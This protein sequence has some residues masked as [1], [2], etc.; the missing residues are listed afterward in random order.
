MSM[1]SVTCSICIGRTQ[2]HGCSLLTA[3]STS[4]PPMCPIPAI[5]QL[6]NGCGQ[7]KLV[8][9]QPLDQNP[10]PVDPPMCP[11]PS[12]SPV[13]HR[14]V[15]TTSRTSGD[16]SMPGGMSGRRPRSSPSRNSRLGEVW[17][18]L[19]CCWGGGQA[20]CVDVS[21]GNQGPRDNP[22]RGWRG[23][24]GAGNGAYRKLG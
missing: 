24:T 18:W 15:S 16:M 19:F 13:T 20:G 12:P 5:P 3:P 1:L 8:H 2:A 7:C 10:L 17:V 14:K 4:R 22:R 9:L 23:V 21:G 6:L 11:I